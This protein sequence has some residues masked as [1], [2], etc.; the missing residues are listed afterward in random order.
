MKVHMR[1]HSGE[2][3]YICVVPGCHRK[4]KWR[5]SMS[6]HNKGHER[7]G[8]IQP[9]LPIVQEKNIGKERKRRQ[10]RAVPTSQSILGHGDLASPSARKK[11]A[12]RSVG[13]QKELDMSHNPNQSVPPAPIA[14]VHP[15]HSGSTSA[16]TSPSIAFR[17]G[18]PAE[19]VASSPNTTVLESLEELEASDRSTSE[20]CKGQPPVPLLSP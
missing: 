14:L 6:H 18:P 4:F 15:R 13:M 16:S 20:P 3:P 12:G 5:S 11:K 17:L 9:S 7:R 10:A 8:Q 1:R 2:T 19:D